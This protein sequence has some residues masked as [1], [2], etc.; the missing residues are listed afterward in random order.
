[1]RLLLL[2]DI[3]SESGWSILTAVTAHFPHRS[4]S[5]IQTI[6]GRKS[7]V[8]ERGRPFLPLIDEDQSRLIRSHSRGLAFLRRRN[9]GNDPLPRKSN[10]HPDDRYR[11]RK[12]KNEKKK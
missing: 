8:V 12:N 5:S 2:S 7:P 9:P 4:R 10:A 11:K 1:M 3:L 6:K